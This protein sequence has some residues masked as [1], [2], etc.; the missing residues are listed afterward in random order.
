MRAT[1]FG[2][3][4]LLATAGCGGAP[5]GLPTAQVTIDTASGPR[6]FNVEVAANRASQQRGLMF[7]RELA[8]SAGMLFDFHKAQ[9]LSFWMKDTILSLDMLFIRSDGTIST[10]ASHTTPLSTAPIPS[11]EPVRAVLE[12]NGGRA[13]EL[14][15]SPGDKIHTSIFHN[16]D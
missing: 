7:R 3:A 4:L 5:V 9:S 6:I 16:D 14:G 1:M 8:P 11:A 10:I 2:A 12:I 13:H 15:I